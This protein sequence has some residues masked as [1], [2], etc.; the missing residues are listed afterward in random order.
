MVH[1]GGWSGYGSDYNDIVWA[2]VWDP[3]KAIY[4]GE[5]SVCES[6]QLEILLYVIYVIVCPSK[7]L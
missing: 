6:G 3:N 4:V 1:L 5:W 7:I 2:I